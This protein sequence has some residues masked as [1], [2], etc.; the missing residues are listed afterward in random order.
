M[1]I[2]DYLTTSIRCIEYHQGA[3]FIGHVHEAVYYTLD[4]GETWI[5]YRENFPAFS[6][7]PGLNLYGVPMS[8]VFSGDKMYCGVFSVDEGVGG[9]FWSPVPDELITSVDESSNLPQAVIYPNPANEFVILQ[10]PKA[11]ENQH[12]L[13]ITDAMGTV[14][15]NKMMQNEAS[16]EV[17]VSTKNWKSGVYFCTI[18]SGESKT[19]GKFIIE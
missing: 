8:L 9:V 16:K 17:I 15:Y 10:L 6:P 14:Q 18:I 11:A 13:I 4:H 2:P 3:F 1:P 5:E 12:N 7:V 19:T